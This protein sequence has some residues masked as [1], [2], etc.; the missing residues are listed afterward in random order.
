MSKG[1]RDLYAADGYYIALY[2]I[3]YSAHYIFIALSL[4]LEQ[5]P[6]MQIKVVLYIVVGVP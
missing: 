3:M 6:Y 1:Q 5:K 2:F 4:C